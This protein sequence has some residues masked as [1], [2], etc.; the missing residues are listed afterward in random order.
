MIRRTGSHFANHARRSSYVRLVSAR[1]V[2]LSALA[3][4]MFALPASAQRVP[5]SS[6]NELR[7]S[8]APIV[9]RVAPA[10]VT[11]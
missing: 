3:G 10:V 5:P 1:R 9:K 11:V 2:L 4:V 7:L 6:T 8:Y